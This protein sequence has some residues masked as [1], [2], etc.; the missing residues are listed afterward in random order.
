MHCTVQ[1]V[2]LGTQTLGVAL[3][4]GAAVCVS[5]FCSG[6]KDILKPNYKKKYTTDASSITKIKLVVLNISSDVMVEIFSMSV[7]DK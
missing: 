1:K 7:T 6:S 4:Q 5:I 2:Y 3:T